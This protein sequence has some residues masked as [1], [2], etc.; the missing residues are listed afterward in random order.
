MNEPSPS[1]TSGY[2]GSPPYIGVT[3]FMSSAEV[4]V[5]LRGVPLTGARKLMVGVLASSKTLA[6]YRNRH[7]RRYPVMNAIAGIFP[8][9]PRALNLIHY[10]TEQPDSLA[11]QLEQLT[12]IG[13]PNLHGFQLNVRW[14]SKSQIQK[15]LERYPQHRIVLQLGPSVLAA[16]EPELLLRQLVDVSYP[17]T[18]LLIDPS[19][20]VGR[21]FDPAVAREYVT[22]L[23]GRLGTGLGLAGGL[24]PDSLGALAPLATDFPGLSIDA[25]GRLRD[26]QDYLD[27]ARV[28]AYLTAASTM[29]GTGTG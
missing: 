18:D 28:L 17:A 15:H 21:P 20:G 3:G 10:F 9:D 12:V 24:G 19:G 22:T 13:G 1:G 2:A 6:G 27:C 25:E 5:V 29:F 14:P 4:A 8:T 26:E 11:D 7:P 16:S 23:W